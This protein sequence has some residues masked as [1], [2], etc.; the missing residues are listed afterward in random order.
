MKTKFFIFILTG[1]IFAGA[2]LICSNVKTAETPEETETTTNELKISKSFKV[3]PGVKITIKSSIV[4]VFV[5]SHEA[6]D[7]VKVNFYAQGSPRRLKE[8]DVSFEEKENSLNIIVRHERSF[9]R[10]NFF[11][12]FDFH[13]RSEIKEATLLI[14]APESLNVEIQSS[15]GDIKLEKLSGK[16]NLSSTGGDAQIENVK[17]EVDITSS[18]GD[19]RIRNCSGNYQI[20]TTGGDIIAS[21]FQ[22]KIQANSSGGDITI[23]K[24]DGSVEASSTGGDIKID[25]INSVGTTK[26]SS[27]GGDIKIFAPSDLNAY[28]D[29]KSSGGDIQIDFPIKIDSKSRNELKGKIGE[30]EKSTII[31]ST[32]GGDITLRK[33]SQE[34]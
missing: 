23:N 5:Q 18:G 6:T 30:F 11:D 2:L 29:F 21:D 7:E 13:D 1:L 16:F 20:K 28:I 32:T 25:F 4:D 9:K 22:G 19:L 26:L 17:G 8:F 14:Y 31:A 24:I 10:F 15:G 12:F 3:S 33:R 27:S 34:I